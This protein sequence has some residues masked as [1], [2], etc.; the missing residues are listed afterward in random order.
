MAGQQTSEIAIAHC[1]WC[2]AEL[3]EPAASSCPSC[4]ATLAGEAEPSLPGVTAVDNDAIRAARMPAPQRRS[5]LLSWISGEDSGVEE[6]PAPPGS[7]APPPPDVRREMLRLELE[8][9]LTN[10][11]AEAESI[12]SESEADA[13]EARPMP[14]VLSAPS[15]TVPPV[16]PPATDSGTPPPA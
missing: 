4:G 8:A 6:A 9:E 16:E 3:R 15:Q 10:L 12:V 2:S 11:Q 1:P 14:N 13:R 7:L 5:R